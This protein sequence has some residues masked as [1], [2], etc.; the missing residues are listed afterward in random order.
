M[1]IYHMRVKQ[2]AYNIISNNCQNFALLMLDAIQI[3]AH[4]EF[5]TSFA[6]YQRA[7]GEGKI[8]D[9]FVDTENPPEEDSETGDKPPEPP[10]PRHRTIVQLALGLMEEHTTKLDN[11]H[12]LF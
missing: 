7:T 2:P 10:E 9:L 5:A 1:V 8:R 3:G 12:T 11:H 6:I 4:R